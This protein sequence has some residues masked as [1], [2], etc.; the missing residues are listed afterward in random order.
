MPVT[1]SIAVDGPCVLHLIWQKV[2]SNLTVNVET[3]RANIETTKLYTYENNVEKILT[4]IE[5]TYQRICHMD[6]SYE[7][8]F[9]CTITA[10]LSD[11]CNDFNSFVKGNKCDVDAGIQ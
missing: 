5:E 9:C 6:A 4:D 3:L 8:I 2:D 10:A 1:C 7:S 11:P